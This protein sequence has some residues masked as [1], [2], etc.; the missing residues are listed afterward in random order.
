MVKSA[1]PSLRNGG[2]AQRIPIRGLRALGLRGKGLPNSPLLYGSRVD[3]DSCCFSFSPLVRRKERKRNRPPRLNQPPPLKTVPTATEDACGTDAGAAPPVGSGCPPLLHFPTTTP[4]RERAGVAQTHPN[5]LA[6]PL[7]CRVRGS[8]REA[9]RAGEDL[10]P[11]RF[12]GAKCVRSGAGAPGSGTPEWGAPRGAGLR[13]SPARGT[14]KTRRGG[15]GPLGGAGGLTWSCWLRAAAAT[16]SRAATSTFLQRLRAPPRPRSPRALQPPP[17][18]GRF[19]P[20]EPPWSPPPPGPGAASPVQSEEVQASPRVSPKSRNPASEGAR[21]PA[22]PPPL[23][24]LLR[25]RLRLLFAGPSLRLFPSPRLPR[26]FPRLPLVLLA[27][28]SPLGRRR[29]GSPPPRAALRLPHLEAPPRAAGGPQ[30]RLLSSLCLSVC[31]FLLLPLPLLLLRGF[32]LATNSN[33]AAPLSA[34]LPFS[35]SPPK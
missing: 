28:R 7:L 34:S 23:P 31:S 18:R 11:R 5:T 12:R 4:T 8:Q 13:A 29:R 9:H 32:F 16:A 1:L 21:P 15:P 2:W 24:L 33:S 25:L 20:A 26:R 3:F 17:P 10:C 19:S 22:L 35:A 27:P 6:A 14:G 30:P